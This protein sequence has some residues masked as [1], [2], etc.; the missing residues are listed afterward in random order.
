MTISYSQDAVINILHINDTH[1]NY[2]RGHSRDENMKGTFGGMAKATSVIGSA[3][4]QDPEALLFH[5]GDFFT[6]DLFF[7]QYFGVPELMWMKQM[8]FNAVAIGNHE[9]DVQTEG[10]I[11]SIQYVNSVDGSFPLLSANMTANDSIGDILKSLLKE[12]ETITVHGIK[13]G[14]FGLTTPEANFSSLASPSITVDGDRDNVDKLKEIVQKQVDS[15]K[16]GGVQ[17]IIFLSHLGLD[18]DQAIAQLVS[19]IDIIIGGHDHIAMQ[20]PMQIGSTYIVQ[21]GA[22]FENVG[23]IQAVIKN[24]K[25]NILNYQLIPLDENIP[26]EPTTLAMVEGL[27]E[28]LTVE[29]KELFTQ[30]IADVQETFDELATNLMI[31]GNH[32]TGVGC[33]ISNAL[34]DFGKTD[35]GFTVSGLTAQCLYKGPVVA[36]DIV[37]MIGYGINEYDLIGYSVVSFDLPGAGLKAGINFCLSTIDINDEYL[38]QVAGIE[39][40]YYIDGEQKQSLKSIKSNGL[41]IQDEKM[42]SLTTNIFIYQVMSFL[43]IPIE[44]VKIYAE[45]SEIKV[46]TNYTILKSFLNPADFTG[47]GK[48]KCEAISPVIEDENVLR[49]NLEIFPNPS[50]GDFNLKAEITNPGNYTIDLFNIVDLKEINLGI[51]YFDEGINFYSID[52]SNLSVGTYILRLKKDKSTIAGKIII[53]R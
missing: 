49:K 19:G 10:L 47:N 4:Q 28:S 2:S 29:Q 22:F 48:C 17:V 27:I 38:P 12:R 20:E 50:K 42:Y 8:G 13:V 6:G 9:F 15:L 32:S 34:K 39:Y 1:S 23:S 33:L 30:K 24:G 25:L 43:G 18:F 14:F 21:V 11:Q 3:R 41:E 35:I 16:K 44:N 45:D 37:K 46:V 5:A 40:E 31:A 53:A 51:R 26:D 7:Y 36:Q 52:L